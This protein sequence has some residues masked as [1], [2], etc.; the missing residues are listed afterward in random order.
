VYRLVY[1]KYSEVQANIV[2]SVDDIDADT[3]TVDDGNLVLYDDVGRPIMAV[4]T[5]VW[6]GCDR[7]EEVPSKLVE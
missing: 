6:L 1:K 7:I 5:G 4:P 3:F 2:L